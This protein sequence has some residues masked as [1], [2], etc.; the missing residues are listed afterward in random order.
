MSEL[1]EVTFYYCIPLGDVGDSVDK[2][3]VVTKVGGKG[4]VGE[5]YGVVYSFF[6]RFYVW[7][8]E[9]V[10]HVVAE[11]PYDSNVG[12]GIF[13]A[14]EVFSAYPSGVVGIFAVESVDEEG[15]AH[16]VDVVDVDVLVLV[17]NEGSVS[18]GAAAAEEVDKMGALGQEAHDAL[19]ELVL[20]AFVG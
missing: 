10:F 7:A 14:V 6:E 11:R 17:L 16:P 8:I 2:R 9:I 19:G 5:E 4:V 3:Q 1:T 13:K 12:V 18:N 20:G 15:G